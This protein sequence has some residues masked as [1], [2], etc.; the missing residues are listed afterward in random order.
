MSH[1]FVQGY[2]LRNEAAE[3]R[4]PGMA[5]VWIQLLGLLA[6]VGFPQLIRVMHIIHPLGRWHRQGSILHTQMPGY[7]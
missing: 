6:V 2:V 5:L 3:R 1:I 7:L 4:F